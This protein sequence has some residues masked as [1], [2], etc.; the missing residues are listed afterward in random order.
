MRY[1]IIT[2]TLLRPSLARLC[3]S[4]DAQTYPGWEHIV[5]VDRL[6]RDDELLASI[7]HPQRL[8]MFSAHPSHDWASACA[9]RRSAWPSGTGDYLIYIDDDNYLVDAAVLESLRFATKP[10]VL[11]PLLYRGVYGSPLPIAVGRS[12]TNQL[13]VRREIGRWPDK[14]SPAGDG[15]FI[16]R[17]T[18]EHEYEVFTERALVVYEQESAGAIR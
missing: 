8:I 9:A 3:K 17:L 5:V 16:K 14:P 18:D 2:P 7:E 10:V 15:I 6:E 11:F 13:M 4:I 1:T 12:D